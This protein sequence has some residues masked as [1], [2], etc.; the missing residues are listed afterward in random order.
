MNKQNKLDH[1]AVAAAL[2]GVPNAAPP[3]PAGCQ[4]DV[5]REK[6]NVLYS[7]VSYCIVL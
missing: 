6:I 5:P 4:Q 3:P 2:G 7:S 1:L